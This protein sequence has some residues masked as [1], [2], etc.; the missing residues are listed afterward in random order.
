M[1]TTDLP[2]G[3]SDSSRAQ[4]LRAAARQFADRPYYDVGLDD[5]LNEA[6]LSKGAMYCHFRSKFELAIT[7]IDQHMANARVASEQLLARQLSGLETLIDFSFLS[8]MQ[9]MTDDSARAAS[10]LVQSVGWSGGARER[11]VDGWIDMLAAAAA[12]AI[13]EGDLDPRWDSRDV[14]LLAASMTI[15]LCSTSDPDD[16][17][18]FLND[19]EKSCELMLAGLLVPGRLEYFQ[20]FLRRRTAL[21]VSARLSQASGS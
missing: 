3:R 6:G 17:Q 18:R 4:I 14:A 8:A 7:I 15:G 13:G 1:P 19:V 11:L 12:R 2:D 5:I 21:A 9:H 16:P 10:R 20:Q